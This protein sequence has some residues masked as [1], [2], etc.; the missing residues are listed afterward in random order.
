MDLRFP[1]RNTKDI[2]EGM[3]GT[4]VFGTLDLQSGFHQI[5]LAD[6][7]QRLTAFTTP[8]GLYEFKR[9]QFGAK[10]AP[11]HFQR[12]MSQALNGLLGVVCDVYIGFRGL[13][14]RV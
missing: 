8:T 14:F 4:C 3:I 6:E 7:S 2:L 5:P 10:T 11:S 12:C 9:V 1:L 13:G